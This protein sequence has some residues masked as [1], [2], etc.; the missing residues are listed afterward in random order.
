MGGKSYYCDYCCC[1]LK[2][3]INVRKTHNSGLSHKM[4]K[5]RYMRRFEE[6]RKVL[7]EERNKQPCFRFLNGMYC[8]F[9]LMCNSSHFN[10]D[11]L[12]HL[13]KIAER[14]EKTRK[15]KFSSKST[16]GSE[17][18]L[19]FP[20]PNVRANN[21]KRRRRIKRLPESLQPI[22]FNRMNKAYLDIEW[23]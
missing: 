9:D 21:K 12:Q 4:A 8:K 15:R 17:N 19:Q 18:I 13:Q 23:G 10:E 11:Q 6:P 2:N 22:N 7:E 20:W 1:F 3:D 5:V 16:K 14:A